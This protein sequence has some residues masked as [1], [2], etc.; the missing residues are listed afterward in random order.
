MI[1]R[2]IKT[3]DLKKSKGILDDHALRKSI[4]TK[5]GTIEHIPTLDKHIANKAYVDAAIAAL[6]SGTDH[7]ITRWH[8]TGAFQSSDW[9][10]NDSGHLIYKGTN[11]AYIY[12]GDTSGDDL[13]LYANNANARPYIWL[14]GNSDIWT[15]SAGSYIHKLGDSAGAKI[16][17][18]KRSD[19][20]NAW[21]VNSVGLMVCTNRITSVTDPTANQDAATK[22][23]HDD[24]IYSVP[25]GVDH[26]LARYDGTNEIQDTGI[27]VDDSDNISA[28]N[29]LATAA[30]K[31][32]ALGGFAILLI[33]QSGGNTVQ[34]NIVEANPAIPGSVVLSVLG[35]LNPIGVF[36]DTGIPNGTP[37]W[38][39]VSGLA[40]VLIDGAACVA[41]DRIVTSG[42]GVP[43]LGTPNNAPAVAVHFQEVG[44]C[45][46]GSGGAP[47]PATLV[48]HFL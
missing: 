8:G 30:S 21:Y 25:T 6:G 15:N 19:G 32:T 33:N 29:T 31:M 12:G 18:V 14:L 23:Y 9:E 10:I 39:V 22:K 17:Q 7:R 42:A 11:P 41:G 13:Y 3:Q 45:V 47:G 40:I 5:E 2:R 1:P 38:V 37:A 43:G 46:V 48:L 36:L 27:T 35:S 28:I 20:A 24:N 44:H 26:R 34:G 16:Y 4:R